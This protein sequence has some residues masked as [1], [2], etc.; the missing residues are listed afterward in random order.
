MEIHPNYFHTKNMK[1]TYLCDTY[2][3]DLNS[4]PRALVNGVT[5]WSG[6][7]SDTRGS[8]M[9]KGIVEISLANKVDEFD[10]VADLVRSRFDV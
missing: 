5:Y 8:S 7:F 6:L 9:K 4:H 10:E 3:G 1:P 2:C